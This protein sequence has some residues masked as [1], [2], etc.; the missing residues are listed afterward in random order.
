MNSILNST[1]EPSLRDGKDCEK[2]VDV[3]AQ[4]LCRKMCFAEVINN[5]ITSKSRTTSTCHGIGDAIPVHR[6]LVQLQQPS[7]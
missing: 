3:S 5:Y 1:L 7:E 6:R 4:L 2:W